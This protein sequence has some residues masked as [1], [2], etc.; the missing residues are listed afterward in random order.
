MKESVARHRARLTLAAHGDTRVRG[1]AMLLPHV[2]APGEIVVF[3]PGLVVS[4]HARCAND[5]ALDVCRGYCA[6]LLANRD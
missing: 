1:T 6:P 5:L 2:L 3:S 4:V